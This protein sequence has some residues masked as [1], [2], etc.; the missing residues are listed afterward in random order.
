MELDF[1][2]IDEQ[3]TCYEETFQELILDT[4]KHLKL[5]FEPILSVSLID[6]DLIQNINRDYR[7]IDR[8]TDVISFAFIDSYENGKDLLKKKQ[9]VD[10][11]EIYISIP[12]AIEQ[13]NEYSHSIKREICFLFIHGLLHLLGYDH[14][15]EEDE[16]VMFALQDEILTAKG[17]LR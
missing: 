10:L 7:N 2:S 1:Y 17:I 13:A 8:V 15:C 12:R 5:K 14:M 9:I 16:K 11:G 3:Y 4:L 6:N